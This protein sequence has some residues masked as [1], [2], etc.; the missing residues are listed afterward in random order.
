VAYPPKRRLGVGVGVGEHPQEQQRQHQLGGLGSSDGSGGM[1]LKRARYE[2]GTGAGARGETP[3]APQEEVVDDGSMSGAG[4][5]K[6][7][8]D[9]AVGEGGGSANEQVQRQQA[10]LSALGQLE[11]LGGIHLQD[12]LK[13]IFGADGPAW[14]Q[15]QQE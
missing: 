11:Q 3:G 1:S 5:A 10:H 8:G 14:L 15:R 4:G 13:K 7:L 9:V 2:V 6:R 12:A